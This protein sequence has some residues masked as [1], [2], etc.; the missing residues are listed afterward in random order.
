[1][2][3]PKRGE[4]YWVNLDP[5]IGS[6]IKKRRPCAVLSIDALNRQRNHVVVIPLSSQGTP[7]PPIVVAVP[8]MDVTATARIDQIRTVDKARLGA[9]MTELNKQ[10]I[11]AMENSLR[12]VLGL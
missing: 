10:D 8:S 1:M 4:V 3:P 7:R 5:T 2:N 11:E 9:R 6:E 12:V